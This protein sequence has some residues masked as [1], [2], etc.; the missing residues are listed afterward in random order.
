MHVYTIESFVR[1]PH[2]LFIHKMRENSNSENL[3]ELVINFLKE[4]SDMDDVAI[5]SK[6]LCVGVDGESIMQGHHNGLCVRLQKYHFPY[7]I[8]I[9]FM[10]HI[11]NLAYIIV[12]KFKLI[13]KFEDL[14]PEVHAY[15]YR[16]PRRFIEF[17]I[18][19]EG[20]NNGHKMLKY[21]HT[22]W[23]S[24]YQPIHRVYEEYQFLLG[25]MWQNHMEVDK[26]WD[27]I[28]CLTNIHF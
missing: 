15:F 2:L 13:A 11:M 23:I 4:I 14:V 9:H 16:S 1:Q 27:L 19:V 25:V 21:V 26:A 3:C 5:A 28:H 7:M 10:A 20:L 6:L 24:L 17:Q 8:F 22:R 18:F 12:G